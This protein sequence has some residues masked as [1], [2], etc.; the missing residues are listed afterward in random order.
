MFS[1]G[2]IGCMVT[3]I[4]LLSCDFWTVKVSRSGYGLTN[5]PASLGLFCECCFMIGSNQSSR[6]S[7]TD[8]LR[9]LF[10]ECVWQIVGGPSV[11]EPSGWRWKEPLGFWGEEGKRKLVRCILKCLAGICSFCSSL[12]LNKAG[13]SRG[14]CTFGK[15]R[16]FPFWASSRF[17]FTIKRNLFL[18]SKLIHIQSNTEPTAFLEMW[19]VYNFTD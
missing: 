5:Y 12:Q 7:F 17:L 11:V 6:L 9:F 3:I 1:S 19:L 14:R 18:L 4:L 13:F 2:F 15:T 16:C 8:L 10:P